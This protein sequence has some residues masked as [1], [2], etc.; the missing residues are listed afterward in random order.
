MESL[1]ILLQ[2]ILPLA[3]IL[4]GWLVGTYLEKKHWAS[5]RSRESMTRRTPVINLA[6]IDADRPILQAYLVTGSTVISIDYFKR[7]LGALRNIFGGRV[8]TYE[9]LID[10]ARREAI[11]RMKAQC[12]KADIIINLRIETS[13]ISKQVG[14]GQNGAG[15]VEVLAYGTAIEYQPT[16]NLAK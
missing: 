3:L 2:I 14:S 9:N 7:L 6:K 11:L 1:P 10:R 16:T 15:C 13:T 8:A 5:I 4:I 12:P